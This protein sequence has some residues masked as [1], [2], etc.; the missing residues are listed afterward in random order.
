MEGGTRPISSEWGRFSVT[1]DDETELQRSKIRL[2]WLG[3]TMQTIPQRID[4][5][6]R[7]DANASRG[8]KKPHGKIRFDGRN[9]FI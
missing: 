6:S 5:D 8:L 3:G 1:M 4:R 7:E 9:S 2:V